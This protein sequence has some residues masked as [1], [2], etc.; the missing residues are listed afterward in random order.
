MSER[1]SDNRERDVVGQELSRVLSSHILVRDFCDFDNLQR[2]RAD[3]MSRGHLRVERIHRRVHSRLS[4]LLVRVVKPNSGLVTNPNPVVLHRRVVLLKNLVARDDLTVRFLHFSQSREKVPKLR[5][6]SRR[7]QGPKLHAVH[8]R[9][10][11][12]LRR[13]A[14]TYDLILMVLL[15][16]EENEERIVKVSYITERKNTRHNLSKTQTFETTSRE[17]RFRTFSSQ[18][19][20]SEIFKFRRPKTPP[21]ARFC[22]GFHHK[23]E[24]RIVS[25]FFARKRDTHRFHAFACRFF[26]AR[27][28]VLS[29]FNFSPLCSQQRGKKE[30]FNE[31]GMKSTSS[32]SSKTQRCV[33]FATFV[34]AK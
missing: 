32:S 14:S 33:L 23:A 17:K 10:W 24:E 9:R 2:V 4:V 20:S 11:F 5:A 30:V 26:F 6:R 25:N 15:M 1:L 13:D 3:S 12:L 7:V 27:T 16:Y 19:F 31:R 18:S 34:N 29:L 22:C 21:P 28:N 8:L